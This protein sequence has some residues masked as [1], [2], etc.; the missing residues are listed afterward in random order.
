MSAS[1]LVSEWAPVNE[2][3][4]TTLL[5][6]LRR[7]EPFDGCALLGDIGDVLDDVTPSEG[8]AE[9]LAERLRGRLTHLVDLALKARAAEDDEASHLILRARTVLNEHAPMDHR[10]AV[11]HLRRMAWAANELLERLGALRRLKEY[12]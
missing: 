9:V 7:W 12:A 8:E 2:E 6:A 11:G 10:R 1:T 4:L 5:L 3:T